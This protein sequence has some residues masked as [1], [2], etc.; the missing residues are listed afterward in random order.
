MLGGKAPKKGKKKNEEEEYEDESYGEAFEE[1]AEEAFQ[2]LQDDDSEAFASALKDAI[3][4]CLE[5]A[6][7]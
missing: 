5:D 2:A 6:E 3:H 1:S 7:E 4:L